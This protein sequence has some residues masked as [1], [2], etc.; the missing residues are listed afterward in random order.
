MLII[1][2]MAFGWVLLFLA[3]LT[4]A[5]RPVWRAGVPEIVISSMATTVTISGNIAQSLV[6][7]HFSNPSS[8]QG[9]GNLTFPLPDGVSVNRYALDIN[10]LFR[11]A[12]PVPK[13]KGTQVFEALE[14]IRVDPGLLQ[15]AADSNSF[16]TRVFP[17][18]AGGSRKILIGYQE[19]LTMNDEGS[20]GYHLL[21][22]YDSKLGSYSLQ[23]VIKGD[24]KDV[25]QLKENGKNST[26]KF[27]SGGYV[28]NFSASD[29]QPSKDLSVTLPN[30]GTL[31]GLLTSPDIED[32]A[33]FYTYLDARSLVSS[34][35]PAKLTKA[36][37]TLGIVWDSSLSSLQRNFDK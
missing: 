31:T 35:V 25:P 27:D 34:L 10:G 16:Q 9:E 29:Y 4:V 12:V 20:L 13:D 5:Q 2:Q 28:Y 6:E 30:K 26:L 18:P 37:K 14:T 15:K 7:I 22:S 21:S 36:R 1:K 8:R 23:V 19:E 24:A 17:I 32:S 3:V 11:E 33:F